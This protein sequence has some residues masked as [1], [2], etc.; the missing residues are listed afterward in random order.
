MVTVSLMLPVLAMAAPRVTSDEA[1]R[2][3]AKARL[4]EESGDAAAALS[5]LIA[6]ASA[7]PAN[8]AVRSRILEQALIAGDQPRAVEAAQQLWQ[9][10]QQR[11]DA[12]V[13]L[14]TDTVRRGDWAAARAFVRGTDPKSG[15]DITE[16]LIGPAL[17][18]WIDVAMRERDPTRHLARFGRVGE[19]P[20]PLWIGATM[21]LLAGQKAEAVAEA[22]RLPIINRPSRLVAA[23]LAATLDQRG[24]SAAAQALRARLVEGVNFFGATDPP[25][26]AVNDARQGVAQWFGLL[27][28]SFART[29]GGNAELAL[30]L[31]RAAQWL[32]PADPFGRAALA[33]ALVKMERFDAAL[34]VLGDGPQHG[35]RRALDL[36]RGELLAARGD[37]AQALAAA[38]SSSGELPDDQRWLIRFAEIARRAENP[39]LAEKIYDRLLAFT[40]IG[41]GDAKLRAALLVTKAEIRMGQGRWVDARPLL[42]AAVAAMPDD[43]E[44]L[45]FA[46]YSA[47]ERRDNVPLAL[48][49]VE[50]AW[51]CDTA[52]PA[53]TDSLGWAYV[54]TGDVARGLPLLESAARGEPANAVINEHL[55]DAYWKSGRH[56]E[57]RYAWRAAALTAEPDMAARISTKLSDGLTPATLAP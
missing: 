49:R 29:P 38:Q 32:D 57:A 12:R 55:G 35:D 20:T 45:N 9:S 5:A 56:I 37:F 34:R 30:L 52:N 44:T 13:I 41:T 24:E 33:E 18:S 43:P 14:I 15:P 19:D 23:R 21:Q 10:G 25:L 11:F 50:E 28:D 2:A 47:L 39:V 4:A 16:R 22:Q 8:A 46:G 53:I 6:A 3:A 1:I 54:I 51:R 26:M 42:E 48:A 27:G 36:R 40:T 7:D 17:L 31:T